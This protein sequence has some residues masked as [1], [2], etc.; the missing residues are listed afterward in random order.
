MLI[1]LKRIFH[2]GW[3]SFFQNIGLSIAT[4]FVL[5]LI[6]SL[7]SSLFITKDIT[8]FVISEFQEKVDISVY[9]KEDCPEENI[10]VIKEKV[11]TISEVKKVEYI[12]KE[13][14]L[15]SFQER[16]EE[17]KVLIDS[18][19]E[20]GTNP[21]LASLNIKSWQASQ[22]ASVV[23]FLENNGFEEQIAKI[24]YF[25]KKP[26]IEKIFSISSQINRT[27]LILS[28]VFSIIAILIVFNHI[29]LAILNS[30]EEIEIQRLVGASN[31]FIRGPFIVQGIIAG[32][33]AVIIST[34]IFG[35]GIFFLSSKIGEIV[36][37]FVLFE[38]FLSSFFVIL[39]I[40]IL[41][42][43]GLGVI[44]SLIAIRKYLRV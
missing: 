42:G 36:P 3:K 4:V 29:R 28:L 40:E 23:S 6:I 22:Y 16:H 18:L 26:V 35:F 27:G 9:F 11:E 37:G 5:V 39:I 17:D 44:S 33:F 12:S 10:L 24:D 15:E 31:W 21:F 30:K 2:S 43:V 19:D 14:A 20:L 7:A 41:V 34:L 38:Y 25:Q 8:Q 32:I 1:V 13:E